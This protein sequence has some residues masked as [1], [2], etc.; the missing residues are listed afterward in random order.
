MSFRTTSR[1][2]RNES[3]TAAPAALRVEAVSV[4]TPAPDTGTARDD[5]SRRA[6]SIAD[7]SPRSA[8]IAQRQAALD[9]SPG[10]PPALRQGVEQLSGVSMAGVTVHRNSPEPAHVQAHAFAQ[11]R[12]IH[13]GP[14]GEAHL[15]HEA[16]HI[17]QQAQGRVPATTQM[18]GVS[19][20]D[21]PSLEQEADVMGARAAQTKPLTEAEPR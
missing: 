17:A 6:Q 11:G 3:S 5:A 21:D 20:N 7:A 16:W 2:S 1:T 4:P 15:P 19:I 10:L 18:A 8:P 9:D 12:D 13:L 14:G